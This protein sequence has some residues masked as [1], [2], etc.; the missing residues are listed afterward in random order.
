MTLLTIDK[1]LITGNPHRHHEHVAYVRMDPRTMKLQRVKGT[2]FKQVNPE[3]TKGTGKAL[4]RYDWYV[5]NTRALSDGARRHLFPGKEQLDPEEWGQVRDW[6]RERGLMLDYDQTKTARDRKEWLHKVGHNAFAMG[7]DLIDTNGRTISKPTDLPKL[8]K[9]QSYEAHGL[10]SETLEHDLE[11]FHKATGFRIE[12]RNRSLSKKDQVE[13]AHA[14]MKSIEGL[15]QVLDTRPHAD[16]LSTEVQSRYDG[17]NAQYVASSQTILIDKD[18]GK[19]S[20]YHEFGHYLDHFMGGLSK[21]ASDHSMKLKRDS[22]MKRWVKA[23]KETASA[24][25]WGADAYLQRPAEMFARY[26]DHWCEAK[27]MDRG[28]EPEDYYCSPMSYGRYSVS[29]FLRLRPLFEQIVEPYVRKAFVLFLGD[30]EK[31]GRVRGATGKARGQKTRAGAII[32]DDPG[33]VAK[34]RGGIR[35]LKPQEMGKIADILRRARKKY[36]NVQY[37][38]P[39]GIDQDLKDQ[40]QER[41]EYKQ[42]LKEEREAV[43]RR[44]APTPELPEDVKE[45]LEEK[46]TEKIPILDVLL[47]RVSAWKRPKHKWV[48]DPVFRKRWAK[49]V[50]RRQEIARETPGKSVKQK[51]ISS[52]D[53]REVVY[54]LNRL[55]AEGYVKQYEMAQ[56][57]GTGIDVIESLEYP[58]LGFHPDDKPMSYLLSVMDWPTKKGKKQFNKNEQEALTYEFQGMLGRTPAKLASIFHLGDEDTAELKQDAQLLFWQMV[59]EWKRVGEPSPTNNFARHMA[60]I[61]PGRLRHDL[62][63]KLRAKGIEV[64]G[65]ELNDMPLGAHGEK[66]TPHTRVETPEQAHIRMELETQVGR[67]FTHLLSPIES[68]VLQSR[69][70]LENR[71]EGVKDEPFEWPTK[72]MQ[73]QAVIKEKIGFGLKPWAAVKQDLLAKIDSLNVNDETKRVTRNQ[74]AKLDPSKLSRIYFMPALEKLRNAGHDAPGMSHADRKVLADLAHVQAKYLQGIRH[75]IWDPSEMYGQLTIKPEPVDAKQLKKLEAKYNK[76]VDKV[77]RSKPGT[78]AQAKLLD[79]KRE[80]GR[81]LHTL[82][83]Q[84]NLY[85]TYQHSKVETKTEPPGRIKINKEA[86]HFWLRR[87]KDKHWVYDE[88]VQG[89]ARQLGINTDDLKYVPSTASV[90]PP[91]IQQNKLKAEIYFRV[92]SELKG[93][94]LPSLRASLGRGVPPSQVGKY[95]AHIPREHYDAMI[96]YVLGQKG[97]V[98]KSFVI[99]DVYSAFQTLIDECLLW[100]MNG[101]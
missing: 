31:A 34:Y 88:G 93:K 78:Q 18:V 46:Q 65:E 92:I 90:I 24:K 29:D 9:V 6:Q 15:M 23:A 68:V 53:Y 77:M 64:Y 69:L 86:S 40:Q 61:F 66:L 4:P 89:L 2:G 76:L 84:Q 17:A 80:A 12:F 35:H 13:T 27:L 45:I 71:Q 28:K 42:Q 60:S 33:F 91:A 38:A 95:P 94:S 96:S 1:S 22:L 55:R 32:S 37:V 5:Y 56:K 83:S 57:V 21:F 48:T 44:N 73:G 20:Y 36:G 72:M 70:N 8:G 59:Q 79:E 49:L 85:E 19:S 62:E 41:I 75:R 7:I 97:G 39:G 82:R 99:S 54:A 74:V 47:S 11:E 16:N 25:G 50:K 30:L 81:Q 51:M 43:D 26:F 63:R 52:A 101:V 3:K 67:L 14:V 87:D 100:E 58:D 10:S 98:K